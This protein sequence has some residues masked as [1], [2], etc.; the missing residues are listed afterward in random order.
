MWLSKRFDF[1]YWSR[2][3]GVF[4]HWI[5]L[6]IGVTCFPIVYAIWIVFLL[7]LK[8]INVKWFY[9]VQDFLDQ[10]LCGATAMSSFYLEHER[11]R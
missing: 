5:G 4:F 7:P 8:I 10:M 3:I 9:K 1:S 11:K 6:A 2:L